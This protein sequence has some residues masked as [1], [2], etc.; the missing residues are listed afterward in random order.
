MVT[1]TTQNYVAVSSSQ[2]D[3]EPFFRLNLVDFYNATG[4]KCLAR[5]LVGS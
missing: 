3:E 2:Y 1:L 4:S 5:E